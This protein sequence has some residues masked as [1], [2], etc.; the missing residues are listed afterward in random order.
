MRHL[1]NLLSDGLREEMP[2]PNTCA[3]R[4]AQP[5][6]HIRHIAVIIGAAFVTGVLSGCYPAMVRHSPDI[7]GTLALDGV[8]VVGAQVYV[9]WNGG[10]ACN[11]S[12]LRDFSDARGFF[13]LPT[14]RSLELYSPI[15]LGHRGSG[16]RVCFEYKGRYYLAFTDLRWGAPPKRVRLECDLVADS[17]LNG[18]GSYPG[19]LCRKY[20][21]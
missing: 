19:A 16:W 14:A 5:L 9:Q 4:S 8:P 6:S 20:E 1:T 11:A 18:Y 12:P 13:A 3:R 2:S 10:E 7:S 21:P 15:S 17:Q